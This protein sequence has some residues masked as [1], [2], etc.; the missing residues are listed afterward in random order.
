MSAH[1]ADYLHTLSTREDRHVDPGT[2]VDKLLKRHAERA[3]EGR[4]E[5]NLA[6]RIA[7]KPENI[8]APVPETEHA[9]ADVVDLTTHLEA[10]RSKPIHDDTDVFEQYV[11]M[12]PDELELEVLRDDDDW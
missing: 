3:T 9:S 4:R 1:L 11:S 2:E 6:R 8:P 7:A 10:R 12:H 5:K